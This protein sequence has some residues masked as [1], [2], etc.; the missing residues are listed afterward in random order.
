MGAGQEIVGLMFWTVTVVEQALVQPVGSATKVETWCTPTLKV[1]VKSTRAVVG[2]PPPITAFVW[3]RVPSML[4][5]TSSESPLASAT[6]TET[7]ANAPAAVVAHLKMSGCEQ[8]TVGAV[9]C[10]VT[11]VEQVAMHWLES[12]TVT[13]T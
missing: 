9:S 12:E 1:L 11:V 13:V 4:Q 7:I 10:T 6:F 2:G 3:T 5:I 8:I